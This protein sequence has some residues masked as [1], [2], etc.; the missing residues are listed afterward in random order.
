MRYIAFLLL[1]SCTPPALV[2]Q[3][4]AQMYYRRAKQTEGRTLDEHERDHLAFCLASVRRASDLALTTHPDINAEVEAAR[5]DVRRDCAGVEKLGRA[6]LPD[7]AQPAAELPDMQRD[8][9]P[10]NMPDMGSGGTDL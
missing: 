5:A 7:R 4:E 9:K 3:R 8:L 6:P 1:L 10:E 2:L